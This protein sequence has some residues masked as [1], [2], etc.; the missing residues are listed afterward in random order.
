MGKRRTI[1][2]NVLDKI[3]WPEDFQFNETSEKRI[4]SGKGYTVIKDT[5]EHE[6][7]GWNFN[8]QDLC[9]GTQ[10]GTVKT[11]DYTLLGYEDIF[12]IERKAT[13]AEIAN[14][15]TESRWSDF[16]NRMREIKYSFFIMEFTLE[17]VFC[18]PDCSDLPYKVKKQ[19]KMNGKVI[20]K[21]ICEQM[22]SHDL[23][24]IWAGN[25]QTAQQIAS[26]LFKRI[27]DTTIRTK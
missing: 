11:G 14:N 24:I 9:L 23:N 6:G 17:E 19:I 26:C 25:S 4:K 18:Y 10:I 5:R 21:K 1:C 15:L 12:T 27:Y 13:V 2:R 3:M 7:K 20:A 16:I 22:L 8:A